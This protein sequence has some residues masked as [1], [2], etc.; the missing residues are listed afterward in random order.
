MKGVAAPGELLGVAEGERGM[1]T[2]QAL[3]RELRALGWAPR[4]S[5]R[6]RERRY[7]PVVQE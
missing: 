7:W 5:G 1:A 4:R 6:A 2:W 3:S